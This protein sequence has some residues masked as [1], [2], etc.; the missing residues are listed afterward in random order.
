[1]ITMMMLSLALAA[2]PLERDYG[3]TCLALAM[4]SEARSEGLAGMYEVGKVALRR[5]RDPRHR[6]PQSICEVIEEP[7]QFQGVSHWRFPRQPEKIDKES[8][9]SALFVAGKLANDM[10]DTGPCS[11]AYFFNQQQRTGYICRPGALYF[12]GDAN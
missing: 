11:G 7:E 6:W 9:E 2:E 10:G 5:S 8:W 4:F 3:R 1:M 12:Y